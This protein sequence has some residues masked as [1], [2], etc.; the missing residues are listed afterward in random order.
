[1][2][3]DGRQC[4]GMLTTRR[5]VQGDAGVL[6]LAL[7]VL[8]LRVVAGPDAGAEVS[9]GHS[10]V[11]VGSDP[12]NDL[13]LCDPSVSKEHARFEDGPEGL[14][15]RDLE[16]TNG[17]FVGGV[18][19]R[20]AYLAPGVEVTMGETRIRVEH[21]TQ[22]RRHR[23]E[24]E[25][26]LGELVGQSRA[27]CELYAQLKAV[28]PTPV[29]VL[30]QGETGTGKELVARTLHQLSGRRGEL[31]IFDAAT[32]DP[33]LM[34]SDLFGHLKGAFT[35]AG[36]ARAGALRTAHG[37]TLFLDEIGELPLDLQPRLLRVLES[38][39][40]IPVGS[41]QR[42]P[43]DVRLVAATHRDLGAMARQG[44]F[45]EDLYHRL[46]VFP[47]GV[48]PLRERA[49]DIP[50]LVAHLMERM[51]MA[52]RFSTAALE[53]MKGAAWEGN[54]RALRN[55]VERA[56]VLAAGREIGPQDL[57]LPS[58]R[59]EVRAGVAPLDLNQGVEEAERDRITAAMAQ[60]GGNRR[61]AAAAL[62]VSLSTLKRRLRRYGIDR[63]ETVP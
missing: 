11:R 13:V 37:G 57:E 41:D 63:D 20:E 2:A 7:E 59:A 47:V 10:R 28:A 12:V 48:P 30:V 35:G 19:V 36:A 26:G 8:H 42:F 40:V 39:E 51:P 54:V 44:T 50:M 27:M 52:G 34:R 45:R 32:A 60:A 25:T 24:A 4:G 6:E 56:L 21:R 15:L 16:S 5:L 55:F 29:S 14:M 18:R 23:V 46:S 53:R 62:G 49:E 9:L 58:T 61:Q 22:T 33:E 38:R 43:V 1:M 31:V 3:D 17:T